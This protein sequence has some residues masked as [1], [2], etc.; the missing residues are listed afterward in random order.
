MG[1]KAKSKPAMSPV[2]LELFKHRLTAVTEEMGAV[3]QQ[4]GFSPNITARRDFSCALF[5][6]QGS[7]VAHAAHIPVHLG[8]TPLSVR[9]ALDAVSMD[10]G[11]VVI[12]NDPYAGGTHLPD[13]TLVAPVHLSPDGAPFAY[14]ADR[15][16]HADIGGQSPGSMALSSDIYQEGFRL[17]PVHLMRRG[18]YVRETRE[19]F[20]ANTRVADERLGDLDAQVAALRAG[21]AR[22]R[23]LA[24]RFSADS[25][26]EAMDALQAYS[27]RLVRHF[28]ESVPRGR[29]EAEDYLDGDGL[30]GEPVRIRV[31]VRRRGTSLQVDFA[32]TDGQV[33]GPL[34][35]NLAVTTSAVFYVIACLAG[36]DVPPNRGMMDSVEILAP[37]GSVVNCSFP[38]AVAG[39]NV[40]TS[41]RIV[42][43]LLRAL[44]PA[45]PDKI[46]AAS[47]GTM[48]NLALGGFDPRRDR[49]FSYY[50]TIPGGAGAGPN[51]P[52]AAALQTHMTNTMN[53]PVEVLETYYPLEVTSCAIRRRSGGTGLH[54][55]GDGIR[56]EVR[57]LAE[58]DAT[59][60]GE[61]FL[62]A[63]YGLNGGAPGKPGRLS[64]RT[65][66]G[67]TNGLPSK[68]ALRLEAGDTLSI[69]TPGGG[70][71]G[72]SAKRKRR[73]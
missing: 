68:T 46:P 1:S 34:N 36:R 66:A 54:A 30:G 45:L 2:D 37:E 31:C 14:V 7:M 13:V 3:L 65:P 28:L 50:E 73:R 63:P 58:C 15:A 55:G 70:G 11:D 9:A 25:L 33:R 20:L 8:S 44:A 29:W 38:A 26:R 32:G 23:D 24:A 19:L 35:A 27:S 69:E 40:E 6:S 61:R 67:R 52:G 42:D 41:Q 56:K 43:V 18:E 17:P 51:R 72:A 47:A 62:Y 60:L 57:V 12:L 49:Y 48:S 39:G 71:W 16:H 64:L 22:V 21:G 10:G 53:T 5:D 4:A 59:F